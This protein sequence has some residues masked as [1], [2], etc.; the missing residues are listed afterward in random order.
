MCTCSTLFES[1]TQVC[2]VA[3][4][5][6]YLWSYVQV[7]TII[8]VHVHVYTWYCIHSVNGDMYNM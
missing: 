8:H 7:C 2:P 6:D 5:R 4:V 3:D 1:N